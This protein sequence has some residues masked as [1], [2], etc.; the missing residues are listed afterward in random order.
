MICVCAV[1]KSSTEC[2]FMHVH[3]CNAAL[4]LHGLHML[5]SAHACVV[6]GPSNT[7]RVTANGVTYY[8][9]YHCVREYHSYLAKREGMDTTLHELTH[10]HAQLHHQCN[11]HDHSTA[12]PHTTTMHCSLIVAC[13]T[14]AYSLIVACHTY[15][16]RHWHVSDR[17]CAHNMQ[18]HTVHV[19]CACCLDLLCGCHARHIPRYPTEVCFFHCLRACAAWRVYRE[20]AARYVDSQLPTPLLHALVGVGVWRARSVQGGGAL[21]CSSDWCWYQGVHVECIIGGHYYNADW[22]LWA[23]W[24]ARSVQGG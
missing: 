16:A 11:P 3:A 14:L 15:A 18:T 13:H 6:C 24:R 22:L 2:C 4:T 8:D 21:H 23:V 19:V 12:H 9:D 7:H 17:R 1:H 10:T 20:A 5:V